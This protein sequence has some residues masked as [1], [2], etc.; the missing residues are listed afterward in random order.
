MTTLTQN[1]ESFQVGTKVQVSDSYGY[2]IMKVCGIVVKHLGAGHAIIQNF[3]GQY[4]STVGINNI[5]EIE[6]LTN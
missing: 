6:Q 1:F 4:F 3:N 2:Y 5:H